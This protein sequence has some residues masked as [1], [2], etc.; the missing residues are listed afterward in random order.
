MTSSASEHRHARPEQAPLTSPTP[1]RPEL[2]QLMRMWVSAV[3]AAGF[4]LD[5]AL[6]VLNTFLPNVRQANRATRTAVLA[7]VPGGGDFDGP[8]DTPQ[9]RVIDDNRRVREQSR[10]LCEIARELGKFVEEQDGMS[11]SQRRLA[12]RER[13]RRLYTTAPEQLGGPINRQAAGDLP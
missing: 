3:T 6:T 4:Q 9:R 8:S 2:L 10:I 12:I 1:F 11:I 13:R 5:D 7:L